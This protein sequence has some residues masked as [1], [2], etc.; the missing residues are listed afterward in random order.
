MESFLPRHI[1]QNLLPEE[2]EKLGP[3]E[4]MGILHR[5]EGPH[6]LQ[7]LNQETY[8]PALLLTTSRSML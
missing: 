2:T 7:S 4:F 3:S 5:K 1:P 8:T 6:G